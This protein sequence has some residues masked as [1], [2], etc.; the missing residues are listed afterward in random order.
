MWQAFFYA[1]GRVEREMLLNQ[2]APRA[3]GFAR[4]SKN[5]MLIQGDVEISTYNKSGFSYNRL[6]GSDRRWVCTM[7]YT[8]TV[9]SF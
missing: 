8:L 6:M 1:Y 3:A 9:S 7:N 4:L 5:A 2:P